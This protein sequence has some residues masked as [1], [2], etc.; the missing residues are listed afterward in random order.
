MKT[1]RDFTWCNISPA[2]PKEIGKVPL[3][4]VCTQGAKHYVENIDQF[5]KPREKWN[6]AERAPRVMV[7]PPHAW[8]EVCQGLVS[9]GLCT[10]LGVDEVFD[11]GSGPLLNGLFGVTKDEWVDDVEV[12][13]LIMN[14]T[15]FNAIAEEVRG[16]VDTLPM[17]SLMNPYV[18]QPEE[19]LII[20]SE[21]VRCFFYTMAVPPP[22][23]KF[24]AFNRRVPDCCLPPEQ[25]GQE[26]YLASKVLPMGFSNSVGL[27]QHVHRNLALWSGSGSDE[28]SAGANALEGE[29]RKDRAVTVASPSWRIYLDNYDLLEKVKSVDALSLQGTLAPAVLALRQEYEHWDIPRNLKKS[30]SRSTMAEVQGAQVDGSLGVAYPR[31][32]KLLKYLGACLSLLDRPMV[33]QRQLQVVCGGLV[34]ISM[35]RRQLLGCLNAVWKFIEHFEAVGARALKLPDVC[36]LELLRFLSLIPLARLDF[37]MTYNEQVTCSDASTS[38][39]G[40]CAS[41]ALSRVGHLASQGNLRGQLP[42][43]RQEHR[44]LTIG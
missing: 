39:G 43:L 35:F 13:R 15:P 32:A 42:E 22:W 16:D 30:V 4:D 34:Y 7:P 27:A 28:V 44:V 6:L 14:L 33:T 12:Y 21:D 1:A 37:R 25:Q 41:T 38:G 3:V 24:L 18:I 17:W 20:S 23:Y 9:S 40:V 8:A 10:L 26:V 11:T 29:L 31:E 5:I 36:R 19:T 2:L